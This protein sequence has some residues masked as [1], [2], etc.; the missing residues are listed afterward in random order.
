MEEQKAK[1]KIEKYLVDVIEQ[2]RSEFNDFPVCPFAKSERVSGK[3]KIGIFDPAVVKF[4]DLVLQMEKDG[5]ESG[6]FAVYQGDM[7]VEISEK[8][9]KK[10]QVFLNKSLRLSGLRKYKT[11]CF[12]PNDS[13]SVGGFS[14]RSLSPYFLVNVA[15]REVLQSARNS[16]TKTKYY[17][18]MSDKYK[19]FLSLD[20]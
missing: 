18:K 19:R 9:T 11:I 20:L 16:L 14:P 5:Y 4:Q 7:P 3:L 15:K 1:D 10:M 2:P 13:V 17:D 6:L 12:N 8:D